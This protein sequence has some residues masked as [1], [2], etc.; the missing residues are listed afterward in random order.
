MTFTAYNAIFLLSRRYY[1][2]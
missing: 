1:M 2:F